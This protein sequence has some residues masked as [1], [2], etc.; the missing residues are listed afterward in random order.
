MPVRQP[1]ISDRRQ[2]QVRVDVA[3]RA[4]FAQQVIRQIVHQPHAR[5]A[6]I[7]FS[8]LQQAACHTILTI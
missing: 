7:G 4:A 2:R 5:F 1:V 3:L 8:V 6:L